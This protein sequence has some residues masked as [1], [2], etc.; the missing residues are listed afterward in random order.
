MVHGSLTLVPN[1]HRCWDIGAGGVAGQD[2]VELHQ[3]PEQSLVGGEVQVLKLLPALFVIAIFWQGRGVLLE[4]LL[5]LDREPSH[6]GPRLLDSFLNHPLDLL[7]NTC[8]KLD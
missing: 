2:A 8:L 3:A 1:H 4:E 7:A 6:G 5:D